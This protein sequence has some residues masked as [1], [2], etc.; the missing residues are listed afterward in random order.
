MILFTDRRNIEIRF[1]EWCKDTGVEDCPLNLIA[2]LQSTKEG[3]RWIV[4]LNAELMEAS[5]V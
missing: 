2:W 1:R 3:K 4:R 5:Y